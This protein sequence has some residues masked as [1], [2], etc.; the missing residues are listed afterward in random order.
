[1]AKVKFK[2]SVE[3]ITFDY[4]GD[5][6]TGQAIAESMNRTLGSLAEAQN[7]VIDITPREPEQLHPVALPSPLPTRKRKSR[8]TKLRSRAKITW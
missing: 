4:E 5:Q 6:E 3:K 7:A 2:F 8:R 1:M